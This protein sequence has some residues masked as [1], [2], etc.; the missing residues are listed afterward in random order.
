MKL[1]IF[2]TCLRTLQFK[3]H[4]C[5]H[6]ATSNMVYKWNYL[7]SQCKVA[8]VR[9]YV[10]KCTLHLQKKQ[11]T[12]KNSNEMFAYWQPQ[13]KVAKSTIHPVTASYSTT[14]DIQEISTRIYIYCDV[15]GGYT[16]RK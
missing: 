16:P 2:T 13:M 5:Q 10:Y 7:L 15:Y 4:V 1:G 11:I 14:R 12:G 9:T 3:I 8:I 6:N